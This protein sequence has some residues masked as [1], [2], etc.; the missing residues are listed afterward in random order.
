MIKVVPLKEGDFY[1]DEV[2]NFLPIEENTVLTNEI[3]LAVCP[4]LIVTEKYTILLDAGLGY[5]ENG[6]YVL[7][8][9]LKREGISPIDIDRIYL[10]HLHKDHVNGLME[11]R[12]GKYVCRFPNASIYLQRREVSFAELIQD[13]ISFDYEILEEILKLPNIV[14]MNEDEGRLDEYIRYRVVGG[15]TA[16]MQVFWVKDDDVTYFYGADN[17]PK[18]S[19]LTYNMA[20]KTDY[21]GKKAMQWRAEWKDE[22]VKDRWVLLLYHDME[23]SIYR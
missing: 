8:A 10:S 19:Y 3:Q 6:E 7:D 18:Y 2:K 9:Y 22:I 17:L 13:D 15:H 14:W 5:Q 23:H 16:Y 4:F 11:Y 20:F 1:E 12:D 21:D